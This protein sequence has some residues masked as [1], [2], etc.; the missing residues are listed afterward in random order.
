MPDPEVVFDETG[1]ADGPIESIEV[2]PGLTR[3]LYFFEVEFVRTEAGAKITRV[4]DLSTNE[5]AEL[6]LLLKGVITTRVKSYLKGE[7]ESRRI[8]EEPLDP[9]DWVYKR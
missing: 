9:F 7:D 4:M 2:M 5:P 1:S 3:A 8:E 6:S